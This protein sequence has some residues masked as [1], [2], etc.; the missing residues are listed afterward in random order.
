MHFFLVAFVTQAF[1]CLLAMLIRAM[2]QKEVLVKFFNLAQ[3]ENTPPA[4]KGD[5]LNALC[6]HKETYYLS[7][8]LLSLCL[9]GIF[10]T[11]GACVRACSITRVPCA[12]LMTNNDPIATYFACR[13]CTDFTEC[14]CDGC[15]LCCR[16]PNCE[17]PNCEVPNC[18]CGNCNLQGC[19][20]RGI[21]A[22]MAIAVLV[23]AVMF[24]L[25]GLFSVLAALVTWIQRVVQQYYQIA[26]LRALTAEYVVVD[27]SK[28]PA[29]PFAQPPPQQDLEASAPPPD[30]FVLRYA[31][32]VA[33]QQSLCMDLQAVYGIN[34][35]AA[36][37]NPQASP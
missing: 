8:A 35:I 32:D 9:Y 37:L 26:E 2:D 24:V 6:T 4:G 10:L 31:M 7:A 12:P 22:C 18:E 19:D 34:N 13:G 17:C 15:Y 28:A 3:I 11:F 21:A 36:V 5:F 20:C 23:A 25:V 33:T 30:S 14:C 16:E 29:A 1:L 27:L